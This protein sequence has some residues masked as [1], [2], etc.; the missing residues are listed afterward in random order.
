[1][2]T[3]DNFRVINDEVITSSEKKKKL[4]ILTNQVK[5]NA[6]DRKKQGINSFHNYL[7]DDETLNLMLC[8][9]IFNENQNANESYNIFKLLMILFKKKL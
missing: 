9:G 8:V 6:N 1:M 3:D 2:L 5:W 7:N 4:K